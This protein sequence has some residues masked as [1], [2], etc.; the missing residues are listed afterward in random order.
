ML[1]I[2]SWGFGPSFICSEVLLYPWLDPVGPNL[3][4][5]VA[6]NEF[7]AGLLQLRIPL[8]NAFCCNL[9]PVVGILTPIFL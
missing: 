4:S 9:Q 5:N 7:G 2:L 1:K 3:P 6:A 8:R